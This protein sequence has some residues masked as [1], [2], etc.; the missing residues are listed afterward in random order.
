MAS[1]RRQKPPT[2]NLVSEYRAGLDAAIA[3]S[4]VGQNCIVPITRAGWTLFTQI[5][6]H[7]VVALITVENEPRAVADFCKMVEE[8]AEIVNPPMTLAEATD[9]NG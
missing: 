9:A 1:R 6:N 3:G 2:R 8:W 7:K 5:E 4:D